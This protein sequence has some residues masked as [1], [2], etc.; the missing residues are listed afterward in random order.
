M[1]FY[2]SIV[3]VVPILTMIYLIF[4]AKN[5][6]VDWNDFIRFGNTNYVNTYIKIEYRSIGN[7]L[8]EIYEKAPSKIN[9]ITYQMKN[10]LAGYL[11]KGTKIYEINGYDKKG[12]LGVYIEETFYLYK[13]SNYEVPMIFFEDSM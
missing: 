7:E 13:A 4:F 8:G 1:K 11:T 12:Y 10:G 5:T 3:L 6:N 9:R 2:L